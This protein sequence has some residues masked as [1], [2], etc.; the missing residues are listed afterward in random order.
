MPST[1]TAD[2]TSARFVEMAMK[3]PRLTREREHELVVAW[4]RNRDSRAADR[5][6]R[7]HLRSVVYLALKYKGYGAPLSELIAAG[8]LGL[9]HALGKF[10]PS[11]GNRFATYAEH[12]IRAYMV[13]HMIRTRS[14]VTG[15]YGALESRL[16]FKLRRE[17]GR[18]K[19]MMGDTDAAL[20]SL[21]ESMEVP[22][23]RLDTMLRRVQERDLSLDAPLRED[24]ESSRLEML[25]S[26]AVAQ[27]EALRV[28]EAHDKVKRVVEAAVATLNERERYIVEHR[29]LAEPEERMT[30]EDIGAE[31]GVSR[32]RVRQLEGEIKQKLQRRLA[33][34]WREGLQELIVPDEA[35]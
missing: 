34:P 27:D 4:K 17:S 9:A 20:D 28:A 18:I 10:D 14:M 12:W 31:F 8:N 22:R 29:L 16:F 3:A 11:R 25:V 2:P 13:R 26:N 32:E 33:R 19:A 1:T 5:L 35:A 7:S 6:A 23:E 30:L 24:S 15:G 21:A